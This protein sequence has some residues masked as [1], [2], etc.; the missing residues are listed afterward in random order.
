MWSFIFFE[1]PSLY[2]SGYPGTYCIDQAGLVLTAV[3]LSLP[4]VYWYNIMFLF[5]CSAGSGSPALHML[6]K[7]LVIELHLE[8]LIFKNMYNIQKFL[9]NVRV[10]FCLWYIAILSPG[11]PTVS[12]SQAAGTIKIN[13]HV[14]I[15]R[16]V[17][18]KINFLKVGLI[19]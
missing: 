16:L 12:A 10:M 19:M 9:F 4:L 6:S 2:R 14:W 17:F 1:R 11:K 3:L 7:W 5:F 15:K 13:N 18:L 8:S